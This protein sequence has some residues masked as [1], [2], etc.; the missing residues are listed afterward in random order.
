MHR[1]IN[2]V[3]TGQARIKGHLSAQFVNKYIKKASFLI[4]VPNTSIKQS[5]SE[6]DVCAQQTERYIGL[7]WRKYRLAAKQLMGLLLD[8]VK[9]KYALII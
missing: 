9:R 7:H 8:H 3:T 5:I 6:K 2:S 1:Y 4:S